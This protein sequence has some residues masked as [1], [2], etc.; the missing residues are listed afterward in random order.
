V[1]E[2]LDELGFED[3]L[4]A[5]A[6][7]GVVLAGDLYSVPE[8]NKRGGHGSVAPVWNAFADAFAWVIGVPG[9]HDD[10]SSV[11]CDERVAVLDGSTVT[12]DGLRV[13]GVGLISGNPAKV[14]RRS[15]ESQL[16]R[17]RAVVDADVDLLVLHEGPHGDQAQ[18]GHREIRQVV[19]ERGVPLTVCG[20]VHWDRPLAHHARG[21]ILNVDTRVVVMT[22]V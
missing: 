15:D 10:A 3:A 11:R 4:P 7:T 19:E 5:A 18:P 22:R 12:I 17:I 13:A 9:N 16:A 14:G 8:A 21:Q 1:A 6:R 2:L 20:H